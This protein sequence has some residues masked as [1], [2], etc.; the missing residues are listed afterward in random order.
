MGDVMK[1]IRKYEAEKESSDLAGEVKKAILSTAAVEVR[2]ISYFSTNFLWIFRRNFNE[3]SGGRGR[4]GSLTRHFVDRYV[5]CRTAGRWWSLS[6]T[7]DKVITKI[8]Y[9][10]KNWTS[11]IDMH[12]KSVNLTLWQI[13]VDLKSTL[14]LHL[15]GQLDVAMEELQQALQPYTRFVSQEQKK[16]S[17]SQTNLK[18][19]EEEV[20]EL[21]QEVTKVF[22]V[23]K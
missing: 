8:K 23:K 1:V 3:L 14:D 18:K 16:I 6:V 11:E 20:V 13:R 9:F 4:S 2:H 21:R 17:S 7:V 10:E 19:M 12:V 15:N 5:W 22:G